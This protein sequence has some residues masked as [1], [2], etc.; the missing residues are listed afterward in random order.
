[1][2]LDVYRDENGESNDDNGASGNL[3]EP[4]RHFIEKFREFLDTLDQVYR[5]DEGR[6]DEK[7][8][9]MRSQFMDLVYLPE[10]N[11]MIQSKFCRGYYT[12]MSPYFGACSAKDPTPFLEGRVKILNDIGFAQMYAD[13]TDPSL[14][15]DSK[16][17]QEN[18]NNVWE[19][20]AV[21]NYYSALFS[22]VP[23]ALFESVVD[24]AQLIVQDIGE[25]GQSTGSNPANLLRISRNIVR[26]A[27]RKDLNDLINHV[28]SLIEAIN[29]T[30]VARDAA[31]V[32]VDLESMMKILDESSRGTPADVPGMMRVN[33]GGIHG[34]LDALRNAGVFNADVN[35]MTER[36]N[37]R[38]QQQEAATPEEA[39]VIEQLRMLQQN[40][41]AEHFVYTSA[42]S[43][44][45]ALGRSAP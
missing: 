17:I 20:I 7:L 41:D 9:T 32:G 11:E 26:A 27:T 15:D 2:E 44:Q 21:L 4:R 39:E 1:M 45:D 6:P 19:Y 37:A 31:E 28:P 34:I 42:V 29:N 5:D 3:F 10:N 25:K 38:F 43:G 13:L 18:I 40:G 36:V 33:E 30:S 16:D 23:Q 22:A 35:R 14:Y 8:H 12:S 24:A